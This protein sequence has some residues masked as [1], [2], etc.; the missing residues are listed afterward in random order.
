MPPLAFISANWQKALPAL[1]AIGIA[2]WI[3]FFR[4]NP[5]SDACCSRRC[6]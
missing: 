6:W 5:L 3:A 4:D 1:S 2:A